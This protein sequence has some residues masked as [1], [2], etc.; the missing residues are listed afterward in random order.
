MKK[1]IQKSL[2]HPF[3]NH[4]K[5]LYPSLLWLLLILPFH[6][7][8]VGL[9]QNQLSQYFH[10]NLLQALLTGLTLSHQSLN[11]LNLNHQNQ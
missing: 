7:L 10:P 1:K 5:N 3:L 4:Q 11:H 6:Y 9:H 8:L 2:N